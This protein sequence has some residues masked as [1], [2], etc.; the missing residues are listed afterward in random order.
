MYFPFLVCEAKCGRRNI[1]DADR[2]NVH[3]ASITVKAIVQLCLAGGREFAQ[4]INGQI[5]V[6]SISHDNERVKIYGHFPLIRDGR[7]T[8][9]RYYVHDYSLDG[10]YGRDR[11]TGS[12]FTRAVYRD[13]YPVYLGRI[14]RAVARLQDPRL[15]SMVSET[16]VDEAS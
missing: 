6:F 1:N 11:N 10:H 2:Q 5:L 16:S 7:V 8:F 15:T 4:D 12:N 3:S 9:H 13:F 14:R